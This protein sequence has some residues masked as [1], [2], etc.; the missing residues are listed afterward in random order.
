M[1]FKVKI[2]KRLPQAKSGGFTGN[3][4]NKQV[5]SFGGADM[6]AASR[7][8]ENTRYLKEVPRDEANLEAEKGESAFGD[9]NGDGFTEHMLIGGKRHHSGGTPLNLPDG[10]FI[11]SDTASMKITDCNILKIF[12]KACGKKGYTPAELAKPYDI[13]KYRT[14]LEDPNSDSVDKKTAELMIKN[15]NLKLGAL[16]LAQE[17]KKGFPQGIPEV[18]RPYMEQMGIREEDLLPQKPQAEAEVNAQA[19]QNPYEN[20]GMGMQSPEEESMEQVQG[21]QNP[22]EEMME[23]PPMAAYGMQLGGYDMPFA[24]SGIEMGPTKFDNI[25]YDR[26]QPGM[27]EYLKTI[28][29]YNELKGNPES[30]PVGKGPLNIDQQEN[31]NELLKDIYS[32]SEG[33]AYDPE[34]GE[35][36]PP[37]N[38]TPQEQ[39]EKRKQ[40]IEDCPCMKTIV[41]RGVPQDKCVPCEQLEMAQYGMAM[42]NDSSIGQF[43]SENDSDNSQSTGRGG[44]FSNLFGGN[45]KRRIKNKNNTSSSVINNYY[46]APQQQPRGGDNYNYYNSSS[47]QGQDNSYVP[48]STNTPAP[49]N[50]WNNVRNIEPTGSPVYAVPNP[51]ANSRFSLDK[52]TGNNT[53][54]TARDGGSLDR[55]A[56]GG[57]VTYDIPDN[58][59]VINR[60]DYAN[61]QEYELARNEKF[62]KAGNKPVYILMPNGGYKKVTQKSKSPDPYTGTDLGTTWAN[63]K[64]IAARFR[65]MEKSINSPD[66]TA[67]LANYT[68]TALKDPTTYMNKNKVV[69]KLFPDLSKKDFKD[70]EIRDA[71]IKHQK[72]N[73]ALQAHGITATHFNDSGTRLLTPEE[74]VKEGQAES[75]EEAKKIIENYKSKNINNLKDAFGT[76]S[77]PLDNTPLEQASFQGF[78]N[79]L[80]NRENLTPAQKQAFNRWQQYTTGTADETGQAN[81]RISPIDADYGNSMAG[82]LGDFEPTE[83]VYQES[84]VEGTPVEDTLPPDV[85]EIP[86][87]PYQGTPELWLQDKV[88]MGLAAGD[89]FGVKKRLPWAPRYEPQLVSR[90]FYDPTRDLA[91]QS[92]QANITNQALAQFTGPQAL[93][94]RSSSVSG[95][96]AKN[97]ADTLSRFNNLNV[98][99]A[100]QFADSDAQIMNDA[101]R[102]NQAQNKQLY[103]QNIIANQQYDNTKRALRHNLGQAYNTGITNMMQTDAMNQMYPQYAVDP[104]SGGRMHFTQ[105]KSG[106]NP[107]MTK[108]AF[109]YAQTLNNSGLPE[110]VQ[111]S[112]INDYIGR[113]T[114]SDEIDRPN[115]Y[116]GVGKKS[117]KGGPVQ[118]GYVMGSNVFPFMFT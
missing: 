29:K 6:N 20:Q 115:M 110:R 73:I 32:P 36:L 59:V 25:N 105:G 48:Q 89:Y 55:F 22:Q 43:N 66:F 92:E 17:A 35:P 41:V 106:W 84:D 10:T 9:I 75:P 14:I 38:Y 44:F 80:K 101:Q 49:Q 46:G 109:K 116:S 13:N 57:K 112:L 70:E 23:M 61:D 111:Q 28:Q 33:T 117:K 77:I 60:G 113:N 62:A 67:A 40:N 96:F 102:F 7:H 72:R 45:N 3:N 27:Q 37:T 51:G 65:D 95:Q 74:M 15:I 85:Q 1:Y 4:L 108:D 30:M 11:F 47:S 42:G 83:K 58:A 69:G 100:N 12:G 81:S 16:A 104:R 53:T 24:Q 68:R 52:Y 31:Y 54:P 19:M 114:G 56:G 5:I 97:A 63:S 26:N 103:D 64:S 88:N 21:M 91:A 79:A 8:L 90:T 107:T 98:G 99:V 18:A 94:A 93:S 87:P 71:F 39:L 76:V 78:T 86:E 50:D 118:L 2:T 34:T 82:Q